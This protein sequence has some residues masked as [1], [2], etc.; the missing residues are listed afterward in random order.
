MV[1][2]ILQLNVIKHLKSGRAKFTARPLFSVPVNISR[3][4]I[5][6][7]STGHWLGF[8]GSVRRLAGNPC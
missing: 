5:F 1:T 7:S 2:R 6:A 8:A 3:E 4:I